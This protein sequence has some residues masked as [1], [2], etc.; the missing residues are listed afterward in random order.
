MAE[1]WLH[2][3]HSWRGYWWLPEDPDNRHAGFLTYH[4]TTGVE[5]VLVG[6][7]DAE[8]RREIGPGAWAVLAETKDFP[9]VHGR[10]G[11]RDITLFNAYSAKSRTY[12]L[13]FFDGGPSEQTL[14]AQTAL[15]GVHVE[16]PDKGA[17]DHANCAIEDT[18]IWSASSA[19]QA[20]WG[21]D[22]DSNRPSGEATIS[23]SPV[24]EQIANVDGAAIT[25]AHWLTLPAFDTMRGGS[26]ARVEHKPV[27]SIRPDGL[28]SFDSLLEHVAKLQDLLALATG[29]GPA[30]LWMKVYLPRPNPE[31]PAT[32][33]NRQQEVDVYTRRGGEGDPRADAV[34]ARKVVFTLE[35]LPFAEVVPRWWDVHRRFRAACNM[36]VGSRYVADH[37][38][39][40]MLIVA[41]AAA[42]SFHRDLK[43]KGGSTREDNLT[44]LR[45]ALEAL[46]PDDRAWLESFVPGGFSLGERLERLGQ[47]I[48]ESCRSLLLPA[49]AEWAKAAKRARHNLSHSGRS[50]EDAMR[51]F[52]TTR[53]TRAVVLVNILLELG[54]GE[55]RLR[56]ALTDNG[57]LSH[58]CDLSRKCFGPQT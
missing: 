53:V 57:E 29:R 17:F 47:R 5:L 46:G 35:D 52:A 1:G 48:P 40:T 18:W 14:R 45:P 9:V 58:A 23:M 50:T 54:L 30:L 36:I 24:D 25:L 8:V 10:A 49:P 34:E 37:Y 41:V 20:S 39:E 13:G 2:E 27:L 44:R 33:T 19:I 31:E 43:E 15:V 11:N 12:G 6:G 38:V 56:T 42:E 51:L 22:K 16:S 4:P 7:F 3:E 21:W 55:D 26:R 32:P 28:G